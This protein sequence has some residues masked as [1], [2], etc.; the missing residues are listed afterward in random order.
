MTKFIE[1]HTSNLMPVDPA[2]QH[3]GET[4]S[5]QNTQHPPSPGHHSKFMQA[6][7][8][9]PAPAELDGEHR[10]SSTASTQHDTSSW[11]G[12]LFTLVARVEAWWGALPEGEQARGWRWIE[13][14]R[15]LGKVAA[16]RLS[17][18]LVLCGFVKVPL[19]VGFRHTMLWVHTS[20]L[21]VVL[22]QHMLEGVSAGLGRFE[23]KVD[24]Q[25]RLARERW[26]R[27]L[28]GA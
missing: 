19:Y 17:E 9:A 27:G 18:A 22:A 12:W 1:S 13:F 24:M 16:P 7:T 20:K 5:V 2:G 14:E 28:G 11:P 4:D 3:E 21:E 6:L 15:P 8:L 26:G 25:T 10:P 23:K